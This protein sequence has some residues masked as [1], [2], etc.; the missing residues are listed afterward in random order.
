MARLTQT[1]LARLGA[2]RPETLALLLALL[3]RAEAE[4]G[5]TLAVPPDGG[6]R[7]TQRQAELYADSAG[8]YATAPP[9][10]S[11]HEY[12]AAFDV[13]IIAGGNGD[14]GTGDDD[15]YRELA[16]LGERIT[17]IPPGLTAGFFFDARGLGKHDP[18]HFQLNETLLDSQLRWKTM[19][20][21]GVAKAFTV[22]LI[23][24][25]FAALLSRGHR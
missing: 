20:R 17:G 21:V 19:Q 9:G 23:G 12:G 10:R 11:R 14:G 22:F 25:A 8:T 15:D 3:N 24:V 7:T 13:H 2:T 1:E 6:T 5:F 16:E 18:F 4:L